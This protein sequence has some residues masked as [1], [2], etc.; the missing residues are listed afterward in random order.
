MAYKDYTNIH[1]MLKQTVDTHSNTMAYKWFTGPGELEG[2]TWT[3]FHSH[4]RQVS[5][6]LMAMGLKKGDKIDILS[7][8]CYR[9]IQT[10]LGPSKSL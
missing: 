5:K 8:T 10:D 2:V 9:W 3:Q 7:Y 6:S 1:E 4:A